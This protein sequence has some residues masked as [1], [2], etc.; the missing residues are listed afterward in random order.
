MFDTKSATTTG[1]NFAQ[2]SEKN[3]KPATSGFSFLTQPTATPTPTP[4][5]PGLS[6]HSNFTFTKET[7]KKEE[8]K[9]NPQISSIAIDNKNNQPSW[10]FSAIAG[11]STD[12]TLE[13]KEIKK[14]P[15][16]PIAWSFST[17]TNDKKMDAPATS[18]PPAFPATTTDQKASFQWSSTIDKPKV[19]PTPVTPSPS[20]DLTNIQTPFDAKKDAPTA[21]FSFGI[22]KES[23]APKQQGQFSFGL[24]QNQFPNNAP[25]TPFPT[26]P[27]SSMPPFVSPFTNNQ[28]NNNI[29]S[30]PFTQQQ[31]PP[32]QQTFQ[33]GFAGFNQPQTSSFPS[34]TNSG[35]PNTFSPFNAGPTTSVVPTPTPQAVHGF[36]FNMNTDANMPQVLQNQSVFTFGKNPVGAPT[37]TTATAVPSGQKKRVVAKRNKKK[38]N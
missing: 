13:Q 38:P 16:A 9:T 32:Q 20:F 15:I 18:F 10:N 2:G 5:T 26:N 1:F 21:G 28:P 30:S 27:A 29:P 12:K 36:Q 11:T 23:L 6:F 4:T 7:E 35:F 33:T 25:S 3:D 34:Q 37:P 24:Q 17:A 19:D 31:Q 8:P 22:A 14:E